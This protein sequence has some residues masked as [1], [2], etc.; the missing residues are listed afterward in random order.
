MEKRQLSLVEMGWD[1]SSDNEDNYHHDQD[2]TA[3]ST[4]KYNKRLKKDGLACKTPHGDEFEDS[5]FKRRVQMPI[6]ERKK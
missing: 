6:K 4:A 3:P 2:Q 5:I 1:S